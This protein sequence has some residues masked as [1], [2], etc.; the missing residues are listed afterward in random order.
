LCM[1]VLC[2]YVCVCVCMYVC[3]YVCAYVCMYVCM[4]V[5]CV[6]MCVCMYVCMCIVYV[7][8][9]VCMCVCTDGC[10]DFPF[11]SQTNS[12]YAVAARSL[13]YILTVSSHLAQVFQVVSFLNI[14][15]PKLSTQFAFSPHVAH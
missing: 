7:C 11:L 6:C 4:Y 15:T 9:Y 5:Y 10:M 2:M 14:S 3:M 1:Y 12:A 13:R 8:V